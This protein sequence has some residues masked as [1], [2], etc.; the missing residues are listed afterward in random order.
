MNAIDES[1][2]E[3]LSLVVNLSKHIHVSSKP[4]NIEEDAQLFAKYFPTF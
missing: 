4:A 3:A 1:A 2:L